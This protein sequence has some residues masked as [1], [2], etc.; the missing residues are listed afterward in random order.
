MDEDR[1]AEN[2][3]FRLAHVK[4]N[5]AGEISAC[6]R[7]P[8]VRRRLFTFRAGCVAACRLTGLLNHL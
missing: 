8:Y 4:K 5:T 3:V 6:I 1:R 2:R 7:C